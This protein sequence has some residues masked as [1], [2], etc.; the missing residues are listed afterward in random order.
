MAEH[1]LEVHEVTEPPID[2]HVDARD[3]A[4]YVDETATPPVRALVESHIITCAACRDEV[5]DVSRIARSAPRDGAR[6]HMWIG[7]AAAAV[8]L[9]VLLRPPAVT[10]EYPRHRETPVTT[11]VAPVAIAPAGLVDAAPTFLWS[12]V[13]H[14]DRYRIRI[15]DGSGSVI[16]E[17]ETGDTVAST[18]SLTFVPGRSYFWKVEAHAGFDRSTTTELIEFSVSDPRR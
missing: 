14:A 3:I 16:W 10:D 2:G 13:P 9:V 15:F 7:A 17:R 18:D 12:A 8:L 5:V 11:T 6:R 1:V 4:A